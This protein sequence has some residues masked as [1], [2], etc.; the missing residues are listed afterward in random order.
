[1]RK[2]VIYEGEIC[3]TPLYLLGLG[4]STRTPGIL[5]RVLE[6]SS[7]FRAGTRSF[8]TFEFGRVEFCLKSTSFVRVIL[9]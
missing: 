1:M 6:V 7:I 2:M 4:L 9:G 3:W 5:G 8:L